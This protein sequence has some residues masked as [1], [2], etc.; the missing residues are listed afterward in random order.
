MD[1][2]PADLLP[3]SETTPAEA[4]HAA[5]YAHAESQGRGS[6]TAWDDLTDG[7]RASWEAAASAAVA[8]LRKTIIAKADNFAARAGI[9]REHD[10]EAPSAMLRAHAAVLD[11][12][13]GEVRKLLQP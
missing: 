12:C 5:Y 11:T 9:A 4:A 13:A 7:V 1:D 10:R 2:V 6:G 8:P 3:R